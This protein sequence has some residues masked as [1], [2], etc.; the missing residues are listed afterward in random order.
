MTVGTGVGVG[1]LL[2]GRPWHGIVHPEVGHTRIPHDPA[3]DPFAG[4]C[5]YHG[6]CLEG[7]ASGPRDRGPLGRSRAG[8]GIRSS[9]LGA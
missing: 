7:L 8:A 3:L 5:P 1:L 6:D 4:V 9:G 2:D